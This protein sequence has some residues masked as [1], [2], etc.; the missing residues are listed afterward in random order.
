MRYGLEIGRRSELFSPVTPLNSKLAEIG[1]STL[2]F[3]I[4]IGSLEVVRVDIPSWIVSHPEILDRIHATILADCE[5]LGD[6]SFALTM[7]HN[8]VCIPADL[9]SNLQERYM[10][11]YL[12]H[13]GTVQTSG[14]DRM[15][16]RQYYG[17]RDY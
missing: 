11:A 12:E 6:Y 2:F 10:V 14:K 17:G 4:R 15:K 13:N 7:A 8:S 9:A 1:L 3:F 5:V 16:G